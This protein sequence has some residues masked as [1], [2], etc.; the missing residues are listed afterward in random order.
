MAGRVRAQTRTARAVTARRVRSIAAGAPGERMARV[1]RRVAQRGSRAASAP[2]V[3]WSRAA[4]RVR[5]RRAVRSRA[6]GPRVPWIARGARGRR[7]RRAWGRVAGR[8]RRSGRA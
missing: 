5:A 1:T 4:G 6:V 7:G 3:W 2:R 8:G